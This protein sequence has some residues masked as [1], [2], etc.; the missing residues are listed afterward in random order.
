MTNLP[1]RNAQPATSPILSPFL[2]GRLIA[3]WLQLLPPQGSACLCEKWGGGVSYGNLFE[4]FLKQEVKG[5][6]GE[7]K[8]AYRNNN[9]NNL[10]Y[11][12]PESR[13]EPALCVRGGPSTRAVRD[14]PLRT[15]RGAA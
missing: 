12:P 7:R 9:R 5:A 14:E 4:N 2:G 8:K 6:R 10:P 3:G 1:P 15:R 11:L 13:R